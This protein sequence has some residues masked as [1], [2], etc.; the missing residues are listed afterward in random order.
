MNKLNVKKDDT[1]IVISGQDEGKKG[2]ILSADPAKESVKVQGV[3]MITKHVKPRRQGEAGGR[4]E[5]EGNIH[6]SNVML[7]CPECGKPTRVGHT[8]V[9]KDGKKKNARVCKK[10]GKVMD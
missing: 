3:N 6:V 8:T 2:K 10:C 9:E 4:I 5:Q 7:V 1:V